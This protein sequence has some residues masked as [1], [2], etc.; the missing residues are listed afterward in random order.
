ML[1][2]AGAAVLYVTK[3]W[4]VE[5]GVR[6]GIEAYNARLNSRLTVQDVS[7]DLLTLTAT[8]RGL[9]IAAR[10]HTLLEAP[11]Y[12]RQA[13]AKIYLWPLLRRHVVL[14]SVAVAQASVRV[15]IDQHN[16][17]DLEDLFQVLVADDLENSSPWNVAIQRFTVDQV[18]VKFAL[19]KQP[20]RSL[21]TQVAVESSFLLEP[22]HVH[23]VLLE[24]QERLHFD[25]SKTT[26]RADVFKK[27]LMVD[28][29]RVEGREFS[30]TGQGSIE[31][32]Q[33]AATFDADLGMSTV[34]PLLPMVPSP[35]GTIAVKETLTGDL[36]SPHLAVAASGERL[37]VGPYVAANLRTTLTIDE[38][39]LQI[40][41]GTLGFAEGTIQFSSVLQLREPHLDTQVAFAGIS[42][43]ELLRL[44]DLPEP[45]IDSHVSGHVRVVGTSYDLQGIQAEGRVELSPPVFPGKEPLP[46]TLLPLPLAL[47]TAFHQVDCTLRL[48][49]TTWA[50]DGLTGRLAGT[51]AFDGTTGSGGHS[52]GRSGGADLCA[53]RPLPST[54]GG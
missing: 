32:K 5:L 35:A 52:Q 50:L 44:V 54:R 47:H 2:A 15:E 49:D 33:V 29:M 27:R 16:R 9:G 23:A 3:D 38:E 45:I 40:E 37:H 4:L 21:L 41:Q 31:G 25:L 26:A 14:K 39:R 11:I 53:S 18:E 6:A 1:T 24:G 13:T 20:M 42:V 36:E 48:E 22:L 8:V 17:V 51:L 30:V 43:T 7:L 19:E 28:D 12:V 34:A 10:G 46:T